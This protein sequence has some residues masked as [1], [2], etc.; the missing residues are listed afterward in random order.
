MKKIIALLSV[1]TMALTAFTACGSNE[2]ESS[3]SVSA[4]EVSES[5][6]DTTESSADSSESETEPETTAE[7][8]A[9]TT[10]ATVKKTT[11]TAE[12]TKATES[13]DSEEGGMSDTSVTAV[14]IE[15][16]DEYIGAMELLYNSLTSNDISQAVSA[17]FPKSVL[18][19]MDASGMSDMFLDQFSGSDFIDND[20]AFDLDKLEVISVR[21]ATAEEL[22]TAQLY[23]SQ[24][25]GVCRVMIEAGVT[26]DMV[27]NNEATDEQMLILSESPYFTGEGDVDIIVD[28]EEYY[29]VTYSMNGEE[30]EAPVFRQSGDDM[31][32]D[33]TM[34]GFAQLAQ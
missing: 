13:E 12:K 22:E 24:I 34:L 19:A 26:Y 15:N 33:I 29:Y 10:K 20:D 23:Y 21:E 27:M 30:M 7:T 17:T 1:L 31:K 5:N 28:F 25:E 11:S 9:P 32:I 2:P 3:S 18:D 8:T 6:A 4:P 16:A 14:E